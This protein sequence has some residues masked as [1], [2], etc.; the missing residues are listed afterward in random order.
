MGLVDQLQRK[1]SSSPILQVQYDE[2][3]TF[4]VFADHRL[5]HLGRLGVDLRAAEPSR[6]FAGH[7][8]G[9]T[10][11]DTIDAVSVFEMPTASTAPIE[12]EGS[13]MPNVPCHVRFVVAFALWSLCLSSA[14]AQGTDEQTATAWPLLHARIVTRLRRDAGTAAWSEPSGGDRVV[15]AGPRPSLIDL[16]SNLD[17]I[18]YMEYDCL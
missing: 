18:P 4:D 9:A 10:D 17:Y 3:T 13:P 12:I 16:E 5:R 6:D 2:S 8:V 1:A 7:A 14:F 11:R 15:P